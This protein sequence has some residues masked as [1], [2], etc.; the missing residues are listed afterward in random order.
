MLVDDIVLTKSIGKG[1]YSEI[2][3]TTKAGSEEI[4]ATR[5]M[6]RSYAEIPENKKR[7]LNEIS[8]IKKYKHPN[9]IRFIDTKKTKS[10]FYLITEYINGGNLYDNLKKYNI[11]YKTPFTEEIVQYLMRQILDAIYFLHSNKII[12][13]DLK[14]KNILLQ[15]PTESEKNYQNILNSTVKLTKFG[16]SKNL[17]QSSAVSDC[18]GFSKD[19]NS[20]LNNSKKFEIEYSQLYYDEKTDIWSLGVLCYEMLTGN[21]FYGNNVDEL[22][23]SVKKGIPGLPLNLS[24]E[25]NSFLNCMLDNDPNKRL[26]AKD[27]LNHDFIVKDSNFFKIN[28]S[29][30]NS[31]LQNLI[32]KTNKIDINK[33]QNKNQT[34]LKYNKGNPKQIIKKSNNNKIISNKPNNEA[35][36]MKNPEQLNKQNIKSEEKSYKLDNP[37]IKN[38]GK[39]QNQYYYKAEGESYKI[40]NQNIGNM[41]NNQNQYYYQEEGEPYKFDNQNIGNMDNNQNQYYYQEGGEPYKF[42]NTNIGNMDN[43]QNQIYYQAEEGEPYQLDNQNIGNMDNNQNQ[44][45]YQEGGEPYKYDNTNIG[46][47]NNNQNQYYYQAKEDPYKLENSKIKN[48]E[49][50]QSKIYQKEYTNPPQQ[51]YTKPE[52][53]NKFPQPQVNIIEKNK[54]KN[55]EKNKDKFNENNKEKKVVVKILEKNTIKNKEMLT[56]DNKKKFLEDNKEKNAI[57]SSD[58]NNDKNKE[59][60]NIKSND[61]TKTKEKNVEKKEKKR[62]KSISDDESILKEIPMEYTYYGDEVNKII[63]NDKF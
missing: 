37:N 23:Q 22:R 55:T 48:I 9:I 63:D 33:N 43:N 4:Y 21:I 10:H 60:N 34:N 2:F 36:I 41:D 8:I 15:F 40:D 11:F 28:A 12:H 31:N 44:Y 30:N 29:T 14:L 16:L 52:G 51:K 46:N 49:K 17:S 5:K 35:F 32:N 45:Y 20:D 27:L 3:L 53:I 7:I 56:E 58:K 39:K 38:L 13:Y 18:I 42:D 47:M 54:M 19:S 50:N 25:C 61:K 1:S 26:S 6:K 62:E 57:K 59:K 24:K